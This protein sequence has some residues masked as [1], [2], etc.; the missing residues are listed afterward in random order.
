MR[1]VTSDCTSE[2]CE[3][4][5]SR[6]DL[7]SELD[8]V[9]ALRRSDIEE[10]FNAT[11]AMALWM[12]DKVLWCTVICEEPLAAIECVSETSDCRTVSWDF[13]SLNWLSAA[14]STSESMLKMASMRTTTELLKR[15]E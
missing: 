4:M 8:A 9:M 3:V 6:F 1:A 11:S 7:M 10:A 12:S 15:G 13:M 14:L 5:T 2:S